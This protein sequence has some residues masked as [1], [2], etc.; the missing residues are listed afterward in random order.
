[1]EVPRLDRA[2]LRE[3]DESLMSSPRRVKESFNAF[4]NM[5]KAGAG[6]GNALIA[7]FQG[8]KM[9]DDQAALC[10]ES[11]W[12]RYVAV[13]YYQECRGAAIT[14]QVRPPCVVCS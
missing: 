5:R 8:K 9:T 11:H 14:I 2:A 7:M 6:W 10:I 4:D 1:M 13:T 12:R 3:D